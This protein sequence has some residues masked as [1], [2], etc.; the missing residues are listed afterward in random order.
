MSRLFVFDMDGTLLPFT[1]A[2]LE[3]A[4]IMGNM[5]KLVGLEKHY[6]EGKLGSTQFAEEV[7]NL[8]S[9]ISEE[10]V[11]KAFIETPKLKNIKE[12]LQKIKSHGA[13]S[14][15]ITSS[16]TFFADHFYDYGFD[17]IFASKPFTLTERVFTPQHILY[18]KDKPVLAKELCQKLKIPFEETV[19]FG[20]S[21]SDVHL[22]QE[23]KHTVSVN[24][25]AHVK[26]LAKF[27]YSGMDLLEALALCVLPA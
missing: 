14:C 2:M 6:V 13:V 27:H 5:E 15:L 12:A 1:T 8:W 9:T 18:G 11:K 24:G 19:A 25:D 23:L 10:T 16:P 21:I 4:K 20:D 7:Y 26:E 17:Y 3:I 22:F